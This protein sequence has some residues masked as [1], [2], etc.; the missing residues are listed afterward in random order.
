MHYF[1]DRDSPVS[2]NDATER[3]TMP[4]RLH[5]RQLGH[6]LLL[7]SLSNTVLNLPT[8]TKSTAEGPSPKKE[9]RSTQ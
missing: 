4:K 1:L 2:W 3:D 9:T 7:E 8:L 6:G 5:S